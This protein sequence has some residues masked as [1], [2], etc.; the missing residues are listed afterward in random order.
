[1]IHLAHKVVDTFVTSGGIRTSALVSGMWESLL[2][3]ALHFSFFKTPCIFEITKH[4]HKNE[5]S[6]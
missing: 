5:M 6:Q 1:M 4:P 3:L 2:A